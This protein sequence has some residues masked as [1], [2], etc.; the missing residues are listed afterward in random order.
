[1]KPLDPRLLR[2]ARSTGRY[3]A[4]VALLGV[5]GAALVILQAVLL[6]DAITRVFLGGAGVSELVIPLVVLAAIV[7]ARSGL[8]WAGEVAAYRAAA[9]VKSELRGRLLT[10]LMKLGPGWLHG[11]RTGEMVTLATRGLDALDSY[12]SRYLPQ[13]VLA[14][15]V[16][17]AVLA[18]VFPADLIAGATIL[19]TL[20][21][22][23]IFMAL[24][25]LATERLTRRQLRAL[26]RLTHHVLEIVAGLPTLRVFNR[27]KA[28]VA[29]IRDLTAQQRRHGMRALR[30]AFLSSLALELLATLSVA[31]VAVGIGLRVVD[32]T[33]DLRTALIVLIL[34]PEAYLPLRQVGVHFHASAEG[35]AA[36]GRVFEIL[37]TPVP[38]SGG[39]TDVP[40]PS[41]VPITFEAVT[42]HF[43]DR[44]E[45]A[46]DRLDLTVRPG[47]I[48]AIT[49]PSGC[50]KSTAANLL[51][52]FVAPTAGR[53]RI[54]EVDL[55]DL[56][57]DAWRRR[58]AYVPQRSFLFAGTVAENIALGAS[59]AAPEAI[60]RAAAAA[61]LSGLPGGLSA[62]VGVLSA[63]QRQRVALARA[64]LR[65][66]PLV[67]LDE[68]TANLDPDTEADIIATI[69]RLA[70]GR[71]VV[72]MAH[73]PA[74]Q[75][76]ADRVVRLRTVRAEVTAC[77]PT[78]PA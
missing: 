59:D 23:P 1:M 39:R 2:Q 18:V 63:G 21:L 27:A 47:E 11:E 54:G 4:A 30:V 10:H 41:R 46:L 66:A 40:D 13:L 19:V 61:G 60:E 45:P 33:L 44:A 16:P 37:E 43:A 5:V 31:L 57:P 75:A 38:P 55:A 73:R 52:G 77:P 17:A 32:G 53:I 3:L 25:G 34:A 65:D 78:A 49:G 67:V 68:P 42:V 62:P 28:Q 26:T 70:R 20:P 22:I 69:R 71:T 6:A 58:V 14:A 15:L 56:D 35:L 29:A 48:H 74:L 12:F 7:L 76:V 50:G 64:F 51:L 36:S 72:L 9:G 8:A 24:I